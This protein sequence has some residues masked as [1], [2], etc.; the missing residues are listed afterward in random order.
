MKKLGVLTMIG[1]VADFLTCSEYLLKCLVFVGFTEETAELI[2]GYMLLIFLILTAIFL[3]SWVVMYCI[4]DELK[5]VGTHGIPCAIWPY[6]H[7]KIRNKNH[8]LLTLIHHGLY[9]E[10]FSIKQTI[11]DLKAN[12]KN[13]VPLTINDISP[14]I[15]ELL[16]NFHNLL[17]NTFHIDL[18]ISI[19]TITQTDQHRP[20][21]TKAAFHR[22]KAEAAKTGQRSAGVPYL[23]GYND[24]HAETNYS[25]RAREYHTAHGNAEYLKNS[26]FDH[27]LSTQEHYWIS[28][29]VVLDRDN[30]LYFSSSPNT[31]RFYR[32]FAAFAILPPNCLPNQHAAIKGIIAF[33]SPKTNIFSHDECSFVMGL[34]AHIVYDIL[35][36]LKS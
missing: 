17:Y 34:M 14:Q 1:V 16:Q 22:S 30:N 18:S 4:K 6:I 13:N 33:D 12:R 2:N 8:T 9:H 25:N 20:I 36:E 7:Y 10:C 35:E 11:K 23:V 15:G 21:L 26:V 3:G 29:D 5:R 19:F 28:N 32:S 27:I 31:E 24:D